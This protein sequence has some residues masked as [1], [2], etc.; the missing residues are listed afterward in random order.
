[1]HV[2]CLTWLV[3][4][5]FYLQI[6]LGG[7]SLWGAVTYVTTSVASGC[8]VW[9]KVGR[10]RV[11]WWTH[12]TSWVKGLIVTDLQNCANLTLCQWD[13][14]RTWAILCCGLPLGRPNG[15]RFLLCKTMGLGLPLF[16]F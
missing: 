7:T 11:V 6:L 1:M 12:L 15:L 4:A 16:K 14:E 10:G 2:I 9:T 5:Y 13:R 8:P 3:C